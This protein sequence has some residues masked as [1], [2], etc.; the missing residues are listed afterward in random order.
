MEGAMEG[1]GEDCPM[2]QLATQIA[3]VGEECSMFQLVT[4]LLDLLEDLSVMWL[5]G[6]SVIRYQ[7]VDL[8]QVGA[9]LE[10]PCARIASQ[11]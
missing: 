1:T 9:V 6:L 2:F 10:T 7:I 5:S 8:S 3:G 4:Q 11:S